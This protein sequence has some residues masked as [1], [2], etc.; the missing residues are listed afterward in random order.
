MSS[1]F[2]PTARRPS[3][4]GRGNSSSSIN[5]YIVERDMPNISSSAERR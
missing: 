3:L 2:Q 4:M 1:D 5:L